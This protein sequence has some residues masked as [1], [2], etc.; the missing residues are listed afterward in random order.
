VDIAFSRRGEDMVGGGYGMVKEEDRSWEWGPSFEAARASK[1]KM[2]FDSIYWHSHSSQTT[3]IILIS[4][5]P[6]TLRNRPGIS[7]SVSPSQT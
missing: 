7:L 5:T 6:A 4:A 1:G 2:V 3:P